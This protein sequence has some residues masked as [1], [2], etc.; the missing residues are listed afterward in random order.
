MKKVLAFATIAL[1]LASCSNVAKFKP[2]VEELASKWDGT[3]SAVTEFVTSVKTEQANWMTAMGGMQVAPELMAKWDEATKTKYNEIQTAAQ[4][5]TTAMQGLVTGM[6]T[7]VAG[8]TEKSKEVQ[9][10]KDGIA[11]GKLE[12]DVQTQISGLTTTMNEATSMLEQWKAKFA[13]VKT[14]AAASQ[15]SFA[16]FMAAVPGGAAAPKAGT[17]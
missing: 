17:K 12:G 15:Q 1:F 13:E 3:T 5:N 16:D 6:D 4:G 9:A 14:A 10:L 2:M 11:A 8:W 7:F